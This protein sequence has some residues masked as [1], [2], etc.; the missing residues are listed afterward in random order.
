MRA[1][2]IACAGKSANH[3]LYHLAPQVRN[4]TQGPACATC[5]S[6]TSSNS[7]LRHLQG[8]WAKFRNAVVVNPEISSGLPLPDNHRYPQP[9]SRTERYA[10][11]ATQSSDI[12]FNPVSSPTSLDA[13][14]SDPSPLPCSTTNVMC[15]ESSQRQA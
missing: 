12:A 5:L 14:D 10:T 9:G 7:P 11:P 4:T 15:D 6:L 13:I 3:E 8:F 2:I 1:S